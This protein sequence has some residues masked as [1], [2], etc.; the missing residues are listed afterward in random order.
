MTISPVE[1]RPPS[2]AASVSSV[3]ALL[4]SF[5]IIAS[6]PLPAQTYSFSVLYAFSGKPDGANPEASLVLDSAGNLYGTTANGGANGPSTGDGTVFKL[7]RTGQESV[8]HSFCS[9]SHCSD[10]A[11]PAAGL[12]R[13]P[14]GNLYGATK[15]GGNPVS[16]GVVFKL[17]PTG[18]ETVLYTF[19][20][21]KD[22]SA[23][24]GP[25]IR[26]AAGHLYGT[27]YSANGHSPSGVAF[28]I[29]SPGHETVL[30]TFGTAPD[31]AGPAAGLI[32]DSHG[33]LFGTT[34]EGGNNLEDQSADGTV[35]EIDSTRQES[36]LYNFCTADN[37]NICADGKYPEAGLLMDANGNLYGTTSGGG[38]NNDG[39]VFKL[40]PPESPSGFWTETVL[41]NFGSEHNAADGR[42]P[43][44]GLAMD[45]EGNL[46]GT[47]QLGGV[48]FGCCGVVFKLDPLGDYTVLYALTG[49]TDGATPSAGVILD[50]AG[51]LYG[52][53]RN[54]G[55][56]SAC[57]GAGCGTVFKLTLHKELP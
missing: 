9:A 7:T 12:V 37:A 57:S 56:L 14:A 44:A 52:A 2:D 29:T 28:E 42:Q 16:D 17:T 5:V 40:A 10:G 31:G 47:T 8:L 25:V 18:V 30:H 4:L 11:A 21:G 6:Q 24:L 1:S 45:R 50:A 32:E 23:P 36:V 35:F 46:Y 54:A 13:D 22:G 51:N 3:V 26:D 49:G 34:E 33:D 20:G 55:N 41:Y 53:T 39:V 43:V 19:T 38:V 48:G 27:T 15:S